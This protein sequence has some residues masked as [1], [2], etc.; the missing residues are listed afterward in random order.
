M[1]YALRWRQIEFGHDSYR[2]EMEA[3]QMDILLLLVLL[4]NSLLSTDTILFM[5]HHA[6]KFVESLLP[7]L[8]YFVFLN[9]KYGCASTIYTHQIMIFDRIIIYTINERRRKSDK[10]Y[11]M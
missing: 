9:T 4:H 6:D 11:Q 1:N 2:V 8:H 7:L 5:K 3:R 10:R